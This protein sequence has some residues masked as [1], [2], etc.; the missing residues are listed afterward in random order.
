MDAA[1]ERRFRD[2]VSAPSPALM[3]LAYLLTGGDR[4]AAEDLLQSALA[5][6]MVWEWRLGLSDGKVFYDLE[7]NVLPIPEKERNGSFQEA[8]LSPSG[9]WLADDPAA[10]AVTDM[11]TGQTVPFPRAVAGHLIG[12]F[13]AWADSRKPGS[14]EPL[15]GHRRPS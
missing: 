12:R 7:G 15:V 8:G 6:T 13:V 4:H 10:P 11:E 5:G 1:E 3:R 9:R 14:W 2:F